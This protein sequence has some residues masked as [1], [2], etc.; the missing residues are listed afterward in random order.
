MIN[1]VTAFLLIKTSYHK[2]SLLGHVYPSQA[3]MVGE[4]IT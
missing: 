3:T 1:K 4:S 2:V